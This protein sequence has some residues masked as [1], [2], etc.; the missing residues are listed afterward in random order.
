MAGGQSGTKTGLSKEFLRASGAAAV[1]GA[2][3]SIPSTSLLWDASLPALPGARQL[4]Q[5]GSARM[6]P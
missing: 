3:R 5:A 4:C 1:G 6:H 2:A